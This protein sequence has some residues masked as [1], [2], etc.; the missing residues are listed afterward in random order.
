MKKRSKSPI[1]IW[2]MR[3]NDDGSMTM[4]FALVAPVLFLAVVGLIEIS[5]VLF[6]NTLIEGGV[7]EASR[8][9]ITGATPATGT[10]EDRIV[11]IINDNG[12]GLVTVTTADVTTLVYPNFDS[13]DQAEPFTDQNGNSDYDAGEP[14]TDINCNGQWDQDQGR[15]GAGVGGEVVQYTV[16][17]DWSLLTGMLSDALAGALSLPLTV[18][19]AVRNEPFGGVAPSC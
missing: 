9:G 13:V 10:R 19:V 16:S 6:A 12:M 17:Y 7:R 15:S 11:E 14:F 2:R 5:L 1:K 18:S 4:E 3:R 8:F